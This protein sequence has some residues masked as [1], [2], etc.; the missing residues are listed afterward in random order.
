M[1]ACSF[2]RAVVCCRWGWKE[3]VKTAKAVK[4]SH[5]HTHLSGAFH[6]RRILTLDLLNGYLGP[7]SVLEELHQAM[8]MWLRLAGSKPM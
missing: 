4:Q 3:T 2:P 7:S 8:L 1:L 5:T 6:P